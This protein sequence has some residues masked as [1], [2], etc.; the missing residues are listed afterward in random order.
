MLC[1]NLNIWWTYVGL[2]LRGYRAHDT[3][4][5]LFEWGTIPNA[6]GNTPPV[7]RRIVDA[8]RLPENHKKTR[9]VIYSSH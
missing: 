5:K 7:T 6:K 8:S 1:V 9:T 4:L 2:H 3:G